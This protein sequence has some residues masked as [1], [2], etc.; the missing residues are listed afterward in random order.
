VARKFKRR[1]RKPQNL[2][3]FG[4]QNTAAINITNVVQSVELMPDA[5]VGGFTG[6]I[7]LKKIVGDVSIVPQSAATATGVLSLGIV[8]TRHT[9]AGSIMGTTIQYD[10]GSTDVDSFAQDWLY[11]RSGR[12]RLG[13]PL[14]ATALD[15]AD[16]WPIQ[17]QGRPTLRKLEKNHGLQ[18]QYVASSTSQ[19]AMTIN[20]R[21]LVVVL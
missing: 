7:L 6:D 13:G 10:P 1:F 14:D 17:L 18:F 5:M 12:P 8:R 9:V 19:L 4:F 21:I 15:M 11:R 3:W 2:V 20:L 16:L